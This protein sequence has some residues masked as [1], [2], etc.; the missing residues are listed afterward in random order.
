[1][2]SIPAPV[3]SLKWNL[4]GFKWLHSELRCYKLL[5][6]TLSY[7]RMATHIRE[8]ICMELIYCVKS[9]FCE[10][11]IILPVSFSKELSIKEVIKM[12]GFHLNGT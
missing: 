11:F 7:A 10:L 3:I 5:N 6:K 12:L 1:M 8:L 2:S 9:I 4:L